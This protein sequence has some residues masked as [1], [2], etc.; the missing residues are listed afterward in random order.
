MVSIHIKLHICTCKSWK[1]NLKR[2]YNQWIR[3]HRQYFYC[4]G[5]A[6]SNR[7]NALT[8]CKVLGNTLVKINQYSGHLRG[9]RAEQFAPGPH[10]LGDLGNILLKNQAYYMYPVK[11]GLYLSI[12]RSQLAGQPEIIIG[13][14]QNCAKLSFFLYLCCH[15]LYSC[16]TICK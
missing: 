6:I 15:L 4:Y 1:N 10:P 13:K 12:F 7:T 8:L 16:L 2:Q 9:Q 3:I 5:S 14:K 11:G